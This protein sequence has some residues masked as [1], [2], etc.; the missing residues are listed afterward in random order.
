MLLFFLLPLSSAASGS[1]KLIPERFVGITYPDEDSSTF[2]K[3]VLS[4]MDLT[5]TEKST[6]NGQYIE[7]QSDNESQEKEIQERVSQY[8]FIKN[9]CKNMKLPLPSMAARAEITC[10]Q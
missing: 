9:H 10:K 2:L 6:Q 3:A 5:F 7:W 8:Y 4:S 1:D